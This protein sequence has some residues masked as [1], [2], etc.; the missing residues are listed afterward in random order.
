VE[1]VDNHSSQNMEN[2]DNP[3]LWFNRLIVCTLAV[4][5]LWTTSLQISTAIA[6]WIVPVPLLSVVV[7]HC[8]FAYHETNDHKKKYEQ[9]VNFQV[10]TCKL[11][12]N[13]ASELEISR[14]SAM[15]TANALF[16]AQFTS[17]VGNCST[18]VQ[19]AK[20]IT[21]AWLSGGSLYSIPYLSTCS[22]DDRTSMQSLLGD[23]SASKSSKLTT[24]SNYITDSDSR[25][26]R[27][28]A[29]SKDL[30]QY[31]EEYLLN[32]TSSIKFTM[33]SLTDNISVNQVLQLN[34][35]LQDVQASIN[36]LMACISLNKAHV[37][38]YVTSVEKAMAAADLF[39][40]SITGV[41]GLISWIVQNVGVFTNSNA[42]CGHSTPNWCS[43]TKVCTLCFSI[44][45]HCL[46]LILPAP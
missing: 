34:Q 14:V 44:E 10:A 27:M 15:E 19:N 1:A 17:T 23:E 46:E 8:R 37:S 45:V 30:L 16:L 2:I 3:R 29:Y 25:V 13:K 4:T 6:T 40:D 9:C 41:Q 20:L 12:L 5:M 33:L 35:T 7:D 18:S 39:F 43:F 36:E 11:N 22:V 42:L 31:N 28:A 26:A 38:V 21:N 32:K 24:V